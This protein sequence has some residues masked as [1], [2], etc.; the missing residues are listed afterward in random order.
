[1]GVYVRMGFYVLGVYFIWVIMYGYT[2]F[3][4]SC[5]RT[6][7]CLFIHLLKELSAENH[8][9]GIETMLCLAI[10]IMFDI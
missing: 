9:Q 7:L 5:L 4:S 6:S 3:Y 10:V 2:Y 1:M 8:F